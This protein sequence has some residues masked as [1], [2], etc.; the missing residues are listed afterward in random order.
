MVRM[1]TYTLVLY[2][3]REILDTVLTCV[4]FA[5][6][7]YICNI[8]YNQAAQSLFFTVTPINAAICTMTH[9]TVISRHL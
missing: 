7:R 5:S 1:T 4:N 8:S 3:V 6:Q 9:L 2:G